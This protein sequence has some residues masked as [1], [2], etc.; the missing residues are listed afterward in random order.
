MSMRNERP[1]SI[2]ALIDD[3][4]RRLMTG[5]PSSA[6]RIGVRERIGRRR[7]AWM[8]A[9]AFGLAVALVIAAV[10][11]GR[12]YMSAPV[13]RASVQGSRT[14]APGGGA[15]V[16]AS[17]AGRS[18]ASQPAPPEARQL[19]RRLATTPPPAEEESPIPLITIEPL[20]TAQIAVDDSSRV[21]PIEIAPLQIE[22]LLGQ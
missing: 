10:L 2:D 11:V 1:D 6:L 8:L 14:G 18:V 15:G 3:A 5:E 7:S 17:D 12:S 9:P 20:T 21:M 22:P 16:V 19:T 4:A 13:E